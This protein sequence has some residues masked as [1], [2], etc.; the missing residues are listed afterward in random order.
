ML[1]C[2]YC[3][4]YES[5]SCKKPGPCLSWTARS[6]A[7][8]GFMKWENGH[9]CVGVPVYRVHKVGFPVYRVHKVGFPVYRVHRVGFPVYRVHRVGVLVYRVQFLG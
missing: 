5:N 7:Q 4:P 6:T 3:D 9:I 1:S 2:E 8:S